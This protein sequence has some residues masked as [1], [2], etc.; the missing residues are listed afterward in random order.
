MIFIRKP[1]LG[2]VLRQ[3]QEQIRHELALL[4]E[5]PTS[6]GFRPRRY[7]MDQRRT[8][9]FQRVQRALFQAHRPEPW[10]FRE[11]MRKLLA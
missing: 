9:I 8:A 11:M 4:D 5:K 3:A 1:L 7:D 10:G 6:K 2:I